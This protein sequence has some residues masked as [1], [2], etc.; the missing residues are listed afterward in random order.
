MSRK[1]KKMKRKLLKVLKI[2]VIALVFILTLVLIEISIRN[3][4]QNKMSE[5]KEEDV[6]I[7]EIVLEKLKKEDINKDF[8]K[9][10]NKNYSNSLEKL[11]VL[12]DK[13][14][15]DKSMWHKATG[16]SYL[17]L[18]DLYNKKY[19]SMKNIKVL[20]ANKANST[21]SIVGD[22]SLADNWYIMPQYDERGQGVKGILSED[23]LSILKKS[24][25]T[26]VNSEFTV[27][28]RGT[29]M[30]GKQYTFKANPERLSIYK[31][32]GVDMVTLA[33]NHV[34]D[35]GGEAFLDMLDEFDKIEM[36]RIGAGH[37]LEEAMTPYYYVL[38]GYKVAFLNATRAEKYLL[39]PGAT[40]DS[41]GVFRC[42][43]PTNMI[44]KIKS[45]RE[46]TDYIVTIIHYGTEGSH[47]LE[48]EQIS[49]SHQYIDAGS[50]IVVGHHAH[51]L[52]GVE[53]YNDKPIIYNLGNFIF[54]ADTVDTAIFELIINEDGTLEYVMVPAIQHEEYTELLKG[55][56]KQRVINDLNSW[57]IN[58][59]IDSEG[60]IKKNS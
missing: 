29:P 4:N 33:N 2:I 34:Y 16:Y 55:N 7:E 57:S 51:N 21:V 10:V 27:S 6:N 15:Y 18:N 32:M 20:D 11:N 19:D 53:I 35:F 49:S 56:D 38:N 17:V 31:E 26:I 47:D 1:M 43:D 13:S 36:P 22:V 54:N 5:I 24:D 52:Q 59:I 39:T 9:W 44:N 41:P 25:V 60:I 40:E 14:Q 46:E 48:E 45:I 28:N 23:T 3:I 42:Y 30:A 37:N 50:D 58:A 12:L 8:I